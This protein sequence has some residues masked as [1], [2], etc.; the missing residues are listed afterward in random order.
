MLRMRN[1]ELKPQTLERELF[2]ATAPDVPMKV[3]SLDLPQ[4]M[5][6]NGARAVQCGRWPHIAHPGATKPLPALLSTDDAIQRFHD[7]RCVAHDIPIKVFAC[8]A[9]QSGTFD[10]MLA[11]SMQY[12]PF[13]DVLC[14]ESTTLNNSGAIGFAAAL[15]ETFPEKQLAFLYSPRSTCGRV[16]EVDHLL[17]AASLRKLGYDYYLCSQFT[18][19]AIP[20]TP[21]RGAW[22][23]FDDLHACQH[24]N[25]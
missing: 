1:L 7:A 12:A 10:I 15:K 13:V 14:F 9:A 22:V 20:V 5:L 24:V 6:Q 17:F 21:I 23:L 19:G 18:R 8:A 3:D 11:R 25:G 16:K 2:T 4:H